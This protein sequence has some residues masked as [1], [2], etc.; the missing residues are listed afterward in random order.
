MK[1]TLVTEQNKHYFMCLMSEQIWNKSDLILGAIYEDTACGILAVSQE[2]ATTLSIT[3]LFVAEDFRRKGIAT[4]L[5]NELHKQAEES[6]FDVTMCQYVQ[7]QN[8]EDLTQCLSNNLFEQDELKSPIY[9]IRLNE[10]PEKFFEKKAT[11]KLMPLSRVN[12]TLWNKFMF[13]LESRQDEEGTVP[14]FKQREAYDQDASFFLINNMEIRGCILFEKQEND[15]ILSYFCVIGEKSP[16]SMVALLLESYKAL[17]NSC[18]GDTKIYM[19]A[20]TETIQK[21]I[22]RITEGKAQLLGEAVTRYYTY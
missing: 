12:R 17:K 14:A 9:V 1:I 13:L 8:T 10:L 18:S 21:M 22:V 3:N 20:L 4:S 2:D 15:Y 7:N 6:G 16:V 11:A 5:L 19:N